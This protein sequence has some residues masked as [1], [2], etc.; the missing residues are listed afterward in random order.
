MVLELYGC[1]VGGV[2]DIHGD[3]MQLQLGLLGQTRGAQAAQAQSCSN[4]I[5]R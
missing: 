3:G 4:K 1:A 2:V 5:S